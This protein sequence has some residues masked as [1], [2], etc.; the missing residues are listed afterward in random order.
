[1]KAKLLV[2]GVLAL[3]L[4][5]ADPKVKK[6]RVAKSPT[7]EPGARVTISVPARFA[8]AT[9]F[10]NEKEYRAFLESAREKDVSAIVRQYGTRGLIGKRPGLSVEVLAVSDE[11]D[12]A[13]HAPVARVKVADSQNTADSFW[14]PLQYLRQPSTPIPASE[15]RLPILFDERVRNYVPREGDDVELYN[16]DAG[17]VAVAPEYATLARYAQTRDKAGAQKRGEVTIVADWSTAKVLDVQ[18]RAEKKSISSLRVRMAQ[19]PLEGKE[20]WVIA[21]QCHP[22]P[23]EGEDFTIS[24]RTYDSVVRPVR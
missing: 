21:D 20:V 15:D 19:P 8:S 7:V 9:A 3:A 12:F 10:P 2:L 4:T 5:G 23:K 24:I 14:I 1:M 11:P 6:T 16:Y 22:R 13:L 18:K 17:G